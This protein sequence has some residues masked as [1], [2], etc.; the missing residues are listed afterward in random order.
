VVR[1]AEIWPVFLRFVKR[2]TV[3]VTLRL[4]ARA[5]RPNQRDLRPLAAVTCDV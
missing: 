4:G 1:S 3:I 5:R 2:C